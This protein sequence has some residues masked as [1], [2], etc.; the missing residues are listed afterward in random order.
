[1]AAEM[2]YAFGMKKSQI[3]LFIASAVCVVGASA[4]GAA[5]LS[6]TVYWLI[7]SAGLLGLALAFL[8]AWLRVVTAGIFAGAMWASGAPLWWVMTIMAPLLMLTLLQGALAL[9]RVLSHTLEGLRAP[10]FP[11]A[12]PARAPLRLLP[13][14][15]G[16]MWGKAVI[17]VIGSFLALG[18]AIFIARLLAPSP[19]ELLSKLSWHGTVLTA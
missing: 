8:P 9:I 15:S 2:S 12:R 6:A 10:K 1:M 14:A 19:G 4:M 18:M 5:G 17:L 11:V 16:P 7:F 13:I 3:V